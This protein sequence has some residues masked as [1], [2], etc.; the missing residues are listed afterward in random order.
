VA[1]KTSTMEAASRTIVRRR[2]ARKSKRRMAQ[3]SW[4]PAT[5]LSNWAMA[6]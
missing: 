5:K 3:G 2:E 1:R 4:V 6:P